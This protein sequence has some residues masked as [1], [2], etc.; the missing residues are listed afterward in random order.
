MSLTI[1]ED[2]LFTVKFETNPNIPSGCYYENK[3]LFYSM[4]DVD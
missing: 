2:I 3:M 1:L 4:S